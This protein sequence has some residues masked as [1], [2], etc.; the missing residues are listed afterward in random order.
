M[1]CEDLRRVADLSRGVLLE[2]AQALGLGT[3]SQG[4]A[5][6]WVHLDKGVRMKQK[7]KVHLM[8]E[9]HTNYILAAN[10]GLKAQ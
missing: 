1:T 9:L 2:S 6:R 3:H 4:G 7:N 5:A 10:V 8:T